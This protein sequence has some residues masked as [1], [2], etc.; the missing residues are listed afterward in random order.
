M[1]FIVFFF[2]SLLTIYIPL[3]TLLMYFHRLSEK[4]DTIVTIDKHILVILVLLDY[5]IS[6]YFLKNCKIKKR[7][8]FYLIGLNLIE[9]G[10]HL[11]LYLKFNDT[12]LTIVLIFQT[13]LLICMFTFPLS[14]KFRNYIFNQ[15]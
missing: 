11:S 14:G 3:P 13:I 5:Y 1:P 12:A 7:Y 15:N 6:Y 4:H 8:Y 9:W 2:I 10:I